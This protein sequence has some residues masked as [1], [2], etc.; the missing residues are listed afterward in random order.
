MNLNSNL[1]HIILTFSFVP[2]LISILS[3]F[4]TLKILINKKIIYKFLSILNI[5]LLIFVI[6]SF[7]FNIN[8]YYRYTDF[9][10]RSFPFGDEFSYSYLLAFIYFLFFPGFQKYISLLILLICF[11]FYIILLIIPLL[12]IYL[13]IKKIIFPRNLFYIFIIIIL[14]FTLQIFSSFIDK[15]Q[16]I[17]LIGSCHKGYKTCIQETILRPLFYRITSLQIAKHSLENNQFFYKNENNFS[18]YSENLIKLNIVHGQRFFLKSNQG[19]YSEMIFSYSW[20]GIIFSLIF[21]YY[22]FSNVICL[23][24][25]KIINI[26]DIWQIY[27]CIILILCW[28]V[29]WFNSF[30]PTMFLLGI[31][32]YFNSLKNIQ[33]D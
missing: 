1:F 13:F 12:L 11:K 30:S 21:I 26:N 24:R 10:K 15:S 28:H 7:L 25:K 29:Q 3:N 20:L 14:Y 27:I 2:I 32:I 31:S 17:T 16:N 33:L 23:L 8:E 22:G 5:F 6:Y 19:A 9:F 4:N 18:N